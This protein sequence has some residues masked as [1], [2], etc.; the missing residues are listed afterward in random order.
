MSEVFSGRRYPVWLVLAAALLTAVPSIADEKEVKTTTVTVGEMCG[1]CVKRITEHFKTEKG[2]SKIECNI[3]KRTVTIFPDKRQSP[4]A[5]QF[6]EVMESL[7]K[8]PKKLVGPEG[9]YTTKP[10]KK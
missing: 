9:T 3:A 7:G 5:R 8:T 10:E 6:W 1:G 2:V 4:S